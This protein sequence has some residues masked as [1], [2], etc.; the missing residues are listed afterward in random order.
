MWALRM[1]E[2]AYGGRGSMDSNPTFNLAS[3]PNSE[4]YYA[5]LIVEY[6][7]VA[8]RLSALS[9]L[10]STSK[11]GENSPSLHAFCKD[12]EHVKCLHGTCRKRCMINGGT[13]H[14]CASALG[15]SCLIW[16]PR[17]AALWVGGLLSRGSLPDFD[18]VSHQNL[19]K[20]RQWEVWG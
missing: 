6:I 14:R 19:V 11:S 2:L 3:N 8:W 7:I 13:R 4:D 16:A 9:F 1:N 12:E 5:I 10:D 15:V 18:L 17:Q 20:W